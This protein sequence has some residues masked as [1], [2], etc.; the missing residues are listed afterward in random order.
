MWFYKTSGSTARAKVSTLDPH[1]LPGSPADYH[2]GQ[3]GNFRNPTPTVF[4]F[5][6]DDRS[7]SHLVLF[8]EFTMVGA[9]GFEPMTSTV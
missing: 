5:E 7:L 6:F 3:G 2:A 9:I 4:G 1:F 8:V